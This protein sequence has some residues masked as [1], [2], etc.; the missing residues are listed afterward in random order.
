MNNIKRSLL[1]KLDR[2]TLLNLIGSP[3]N[4]LNSHELFTLPNF[5][6][7]CVEHYIENYPKSAIRY[8]R[9]KL[10]DEDMYGLY[11]RG[12]DAQGRMY[13]GS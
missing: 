8:L 9:D 7:S 3:A 5:D 2:E 6:R 4:N 11:K 1:S 10:T 12:Y 13:P